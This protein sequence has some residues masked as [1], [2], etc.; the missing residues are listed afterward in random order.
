MA[1]K[2]YVHKGFQV[3]DWRMT[4]RI[5]YL[6]NPINNEIFYVGKTSYPIS[7]RLTN[8][9]GQAKLPHAQFKNT[10]KDETILLIL[11]DGKRPQVHLIEEIISHCR[12]D[13]LLASDRELFWIKEYLKIGHPLLNIEGTGDSDSNTQYRE[14]LKDK[15]KGVLHYRN[16]VSYYVGNQVFY[17]LVRLDQDKGKSVPSIGSAA[18]FMRYGETRHGQLDEN[19]NRI[20]PEKPESDIKNIT[21]DSN[22]YNDFD[23]TKG[24]YDED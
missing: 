15:S 23:E 22:A 20:I 9:I 3:G 12:I 2:T 17:D 21:Y 13:D 5:Y 4:N 1:I 18:F 14:Y 10:A 19:G 11:K 7:T 24:E 8:H 6:V 16:Y